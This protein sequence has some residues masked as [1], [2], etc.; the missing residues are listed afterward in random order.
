MLTR[1][2]RLV[3]FVTLTGSVTHRVAGNATAEVGKIRD[4]DWVTHGLAGSVTRN[5]DIIC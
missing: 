1:Q 5:D 2:V 3:K 4:T